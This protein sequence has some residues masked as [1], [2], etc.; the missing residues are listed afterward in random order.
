MDGHDRK[1]NVVEQLIVI[2][3]RHAG[4]EEDHQLLLAVLLQK[5][6][7]QEEPLLR[8]TNHIPLKATK[9]ASAHLHVFD[10][11]KSGQNPADDLLQTVHGGLLFVIINTNVEWLL[12]QGDASEIL[13]PSGLSCREQHSLPPFCT[14]W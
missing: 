10:T 11:E 13:N 12:F 6:E 9:T 14:P 5:G 4:R 1:V 2:F 8:W 3:D 7:E